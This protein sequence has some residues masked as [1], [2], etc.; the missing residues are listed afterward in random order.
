MTPK[1]L[2]I[3]VV[4]PCLND[5]RRLELTMRSIHD[6]GYADLE[7]IVIDGG[8]TDGSLEI[9][10][11]FTPRLA[12]WCSEHDDGHGD[13]LG[14][15]LDRATGDVVTW[16]CSNDLLLP[17]SLAT[18]GQYFATHPQTDWLVGNGLVIDEQSRV[19]S[20]VWAVPFTVRSI[21]FWE[22]WGTCQPAVF[23]RRSAFEEVGGIDRRLNVAVD[24]DL[25]I[26]LARLSKPTRINSFLGA[27]RFHADSQSNL[28]SREVRETDE[29]IRQR[30]GRPSWP[31]MILRIIH[32]LYGWRFRGIQ[33]LNEALRFNKPYPI[34]VPVYA[35]S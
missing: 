15:G 18:V 8:S 23:I 24:T 14:K 12:Y 32:R 27:L 28:C 11:H 33:R 6:Q 25:F 9:I 13:A 30:E 22:L 31:P 10:Q 1:P 2:T 35:S 20:R 21:L 3:S 4:T 7:H 29:R 5:A 16:V 34:G 19:S 26:R 17:G